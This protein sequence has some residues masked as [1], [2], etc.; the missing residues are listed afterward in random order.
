MKRRIHA[1]SL[2]IAPRS[3]LEQ[4]TD[5]SELGVV[6]HGFWEKVYILEGDLYDLTLGEDSLLEATPVDLPV[7]SM[8]HGGPVRD[9]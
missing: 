6:R 7:C 4:G 3:R 9:A 8:A 5:T 2:E 1:R